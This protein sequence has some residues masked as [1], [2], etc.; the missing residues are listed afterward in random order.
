M[1][2]MMT[3]LATSVRALLAISRSMLVMEE[4]GKAKPAREPLGSLPACL[5][6][7]KGATDTQTHAGPASWAHTLESSLPRPDPAFQAPDGGSW[8]NKQISVQR[9]EGPRKAR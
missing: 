5:R 7:L 1:T 2:C 4:R 6:A 9:S 3:R 8:V